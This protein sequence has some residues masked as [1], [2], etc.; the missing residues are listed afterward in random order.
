VL[1]TN[2]E[3]PPHWNWTYKFQVKDQIGSFFYFPSTRF[4]RAAGGYGGI[5][6]DAPRVPPPFLEPSVDVSVLIGD[7]YTSSHKV[8]IS[9]SQPYGLQ[10]SNSLS[11]VIMIGTF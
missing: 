6:I 8:R 1:G 9:R 4:Q 5:R 7:W 11:F 3:I 2:C 10:E